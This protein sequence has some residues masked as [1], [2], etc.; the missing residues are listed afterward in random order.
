MRFRRFQDRYQLRLEAGDTVAHRLLTWLAR[1]R[2]G[3]A[4]MTGLGAVSSA[5]VAYWNAETREYEHHRLDE[6]LEIVSLIGNVTI[7]D[8]APFTHIHVTLGAK[9]LS[10]RGG[11]FIDATVNPNLEIWVRPESAGLERTLDEQSG[12]YLMDLPEHG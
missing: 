1:N 5:T 7:K 2:I 11:H 10:I 9:D 6:Q 4:T 12:L 8:G 3:Y